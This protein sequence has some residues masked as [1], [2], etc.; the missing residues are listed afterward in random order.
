MADLENKT[1]FCEKCKRTMSADQFYASNNLDKYPNEGKLK[2]CKKCITMHVDNWNPETYL[3][4]LQECDVPYIPEEWHKLMSS[5]ARDKSKVTGMTILGRYLSKMKLNQWKKYRWEDNEFLQEQADAKTRETM[6]RQGYKQSEIDTVLQEG[7]FVIPEGELV[8]PV[9]ADS[10]PEGV[11][12]DY[13]AQHCAVP[14]E[15]IQLDL[16]EEEMIALRLKWG[17]TYR[18]EEW[19]KLEQL[20]EEMMNSYDIQSAG[21][22]DTLKLVCKTSLKA[23]QLLDIG[24]VDGAQKMVKMY[25]GLMKSGKFTAA[26][27]KAES[28]EYVDSVSELVAICETEGFIPRYYVDEPKDKV[29]RVLQ[30]LQNYTHSLVTEEMNLGNLIE[31]AVKQ[32]ELDKEKEAQGDAEAA[33]DEDLLDNLLFSDEAESVIKDEDFET[34]YN[35]EEELAALDDQYLSSLSEGG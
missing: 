26:Q 25:D 28:G 27:N 21:H 7:R 12:E 10:E 1:Y 29:D 19:I 2:Q 24:D 11:Q 30:D 16:T 22:I 33:D 3:W 6:E 17:K 8:E 13:F 14:E 9:Y 5:Y 4:I 32:I 18:P 20:Y 31:N 23:N 35:Y 34:F 15:D